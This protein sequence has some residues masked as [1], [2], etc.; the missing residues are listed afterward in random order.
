MI[1][2]LVEDLH[3]SPRT[4]QHHFQKKLGLTPKQY[5][6][7]LRFDAVRKELVASDP[8]L[9]NISDVALKYGFFHASHF[10]AEYRRVFGET[11]SQT[12]KR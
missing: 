3:I 5:L 12:L 1:N 10:G 11:P 9:I 2:D 6:Q 4:L 8:M 7:Q